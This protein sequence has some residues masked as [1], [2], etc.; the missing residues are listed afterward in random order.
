MKIETF[1]QAV[2]LRNDIELLQRAISEM[3]CYGV[4]S[5]RDICKT[6]DEMYSLYE[7]DLAASFSLISGYSDAEYASLVSKVSF[8]LRKLLTE[9]TELFLLLTDDCSL[10]SKISDNG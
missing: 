9:K 6:D 7:A 8:A 3:A 1:N 5:V 10:P 4:R 2:A